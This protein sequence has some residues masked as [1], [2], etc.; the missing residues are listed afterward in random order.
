MLNEDV[1]QSL[2]KRWARR[3]SNERVKYTLDQLVINGSSVRVRLKCTGSLGEHIREQTL[4]K[5]H[6]KIIKTKTEADYP[7]LNF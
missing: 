2:L 1:L 7:G 6:I 5:K 3:I 4:T